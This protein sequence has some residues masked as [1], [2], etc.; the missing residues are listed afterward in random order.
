MNKAKYLLVAVFAG[1]LM[2]LTGCGS[3]NNTYNSFGSS[4]F[5]S[6]DAEQALQTLKVDDK[7]ATLTVDYYAETGLLGS[8]KHFS[9]EVSGDVDQ[10]AK[11]MTFSLDGKSFKMNY[12]VDGDKLTLSAKGESM[13]FYTKGS[14]QYTKN[15]QN[16][17]ASQSSLMD[18]SSRSADEADSTDDEESSSSSTDDSDTTQMSDDD[19]TAFAKKVVQS[20]VPDLRKTL[21]GSWKFSDHSTSWPT[22]AT[23]SFTTDGKYS[24]NI[25]APEPD[26][27][28][29]DL[30][31][32][33]TYQID[34]GKLT[35]D[36][37]SAAEFTDMHDVKTFSD[38]KA[39]MPDYY[40]PMTTDY[41]ESGKLNSQAT[42]AHKTGAIDFHLVNNTFRVQSATQIADFSALGTEFTKT[43]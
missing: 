4:S 21:A 7:K 41:T 35:A 24:G 31:M 20:V 11:T 23:L 42:N 32:S 12:A 6:A 33:G 16:F 5:A 8:I 40:F 1:V 39:A 3:I 13:V 26:W 9:T 22:D 18:Q 25:Q 37:A 27:S 34:E 14:K 28:A 17:S 38:L 36:V 2:L 19:R 43:N 15:R 10:S 30:K 29:T